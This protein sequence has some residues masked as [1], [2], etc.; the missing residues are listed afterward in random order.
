M[1]KNLLCAARLIA[2]C[3]LLSW[4]ALATP[5]F[6][7]TPDG[8]APNSLPPLQIAHQSGLKVV[9]QVNEDSTIPNG[10]AKQVLAAKNLLDQYRAIGMKPGQDFEIAMV[11]RGDGAQFLLTDAAYDEKVAQPHGEGNPSQKLLDALAQGG[12]KFYECGV[13]MRMKGYVPKDIR[14]DGRMVVSGI[15]ALVDFQKSGYV[16]VTP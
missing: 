4:Q 15:G 14:P 13:A 9:V 11:F 10:I 3:A 7:Q 6:A 16:E 5:A 12:V 2:A 1:T 8:A